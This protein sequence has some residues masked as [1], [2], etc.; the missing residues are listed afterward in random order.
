MNKTRLLKVAC[1]LFSFC[2][3]SAIASSAQVLTTLHSFAGSP[4]DGSEPLAG[5]VQA[6]DGNLYGTTWQGGAYGDGVVFKITPSGT[7]ATLYNFCSQSNSADGRRPGASGE[8]SQ[9]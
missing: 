6:N 7:L 4:S 5:L 3:A 2:V 1:I 8:D 9:G